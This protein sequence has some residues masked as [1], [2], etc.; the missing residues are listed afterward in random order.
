MCSS[1][2]GDVAIDGAGITRSFR[3]NYRGSTSG[4]IT[5][6]PLTGRPIDLVVDKVMNILFHNLSDG[7]LL[8]NNVMVNSFVSTFRQNASHALTP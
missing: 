7:F 2:C 8:L 5:A 1:C 3:S 6:S 4:A